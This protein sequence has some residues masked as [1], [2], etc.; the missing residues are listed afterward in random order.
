M[1]ELAQHGATVLAVNIIK[2]I[3]DKRFGNVMIK[4]LTR[5]DQ[6]IPSSQSLF[7]EIPNSF[8]TITLPERNIRI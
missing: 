7:H 5:S 6:D 4:L 3:T 8:M 1:F 2:Y